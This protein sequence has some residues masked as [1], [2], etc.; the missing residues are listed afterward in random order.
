M[1]DFGLSMR[2]PIESGEY[3]TVVLASLVDGYLL[4]LSF[5]V[6]S[7]FCHLSFGLFF[8]VFTPLSSGAMCA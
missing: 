3:F 1:M 4:L 7:V 8:A 6:F 2:I 5:F